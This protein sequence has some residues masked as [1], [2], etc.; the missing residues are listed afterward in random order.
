MTKREKAEKYSSA[1]GTIS[2]KQ[3]HVEI[4][5]TEDVRS[6]YDFFDDLTLLHN[7]L[8]E[9]DKAEVSLA[10]SFLGTPLGAPLM[11]ASMT[12]G[13]PG[14]EEINRSLAYAASVHR[15]ALGVG[16]QRAAL[17]SPE[18][19]RTYTAVRDHDVPFVAANIGAP[20]LIEQGGAALEREE[21]ASLVSMLEADAL[22]IHLNYVQEVV[23]PG[24]DHNARGV[25][26]AISRVCEEVGV[27]V[28]AKETGAGVHRRTALDLKR[29]GVSAIDVGGLSGTTFAAVEL[30]RAQ[31][32]GEERLVRMGEL[33]RDW[34][35]PTP[36]A[37]V[38]AL[39][40]G[41]PV[42]ATGGIQSGQTGAKALAL[43][44]SMAGM[45]GAALR[46]AVKGEKAAAAFL[47]AVLDEMR[48][49]LFLCGCA[50]VGDATRAP[51]LVSGKTAEW[52]R[53]LGH[54]P[55][56]FGGERLR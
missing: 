35:L 28:I 14:A 30:V 15:L 29:A 39:E 11:I 33:F 42:V 54:A 16:S 19:K 53:A 52:F 38:E 24:G 34:G 18:M 23:Q 17:K 55:E 36:V 43:G 5:L 49:T 25:L 31:R 46:A 3:E 4:N 44:A 22:I 45:A 50:G 7:A 26:A 48:T 13:Y 8:P 9:V 10:T 20:Q 6:R 56:R 12:G 47:E 32:E 1:K 2:R 21:I 37:I 40:S 27:P 51:L 41:L